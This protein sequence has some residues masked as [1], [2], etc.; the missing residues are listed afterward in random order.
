MGSLI[1]LLSPDELAW[2]VTDVERREVRLVDAIVEA[3][4]FQ[5]MLAAI[6]VTYA[7]VR[8]VRR[9]SGNRLPNAFTRP[10]FAVLLL[11]V[12]GYASNFL[13]HG[14]A[15]RET[16]RWIARDLLKGQTFYGAYSDSDL[17]DESAERFRSIG[18][19][20]LRLPA[21]RYYDS[22]PRAEVGPSYFP[23]PFLI[24]VGYSCYASSPG[25]N[26]DGSCLVV[27]FFG[28]AAVVRRDSLLLWKLVPYFRPW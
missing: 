4:L 6:I 3:P 28:F 12:A 9:F 11:I 17:M 5:G 23:A 10:A 15:E 8:A 26:L 16:A 19:A 20:V 18:T 14:A 7:L 27:N 22:E 13:S 25:P 2:L 21:D 1:C 24:S